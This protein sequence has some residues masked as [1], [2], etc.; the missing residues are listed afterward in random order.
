M[1]EKKYTKEDAEARIEEF[2]DMVLDDADFDLTYD[3]TGA[4]VFTPTSKTPIS[5]FA[6]KARTWKFCSATKQ[7]SCWPWSS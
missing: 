4:K 2:L 3:I 5:W 7:S 6:S 1:A